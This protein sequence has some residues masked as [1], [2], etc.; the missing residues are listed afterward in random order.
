MGTLLVKKTS[1]LATKDKIM[2]NH[3]SQLQLKTFLIY[4]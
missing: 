4:L 3:F 1:N 2:F